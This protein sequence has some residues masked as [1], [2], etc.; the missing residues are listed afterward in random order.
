MI[1]LSNAFSLNMLPGGT[2]R[3][4]VKEVD[5][6]RVKEM[7]SS[8]FR[9]VVGHASTASVLSALLG[10]DVEVRREQ[11]KLQKN[12]TCIVF[13]LQVRLEEGK[14]LSEEELQTLPYKFY[15]VKIEEVET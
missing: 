5:V 6:E 4:E 3:L 1:Y 10:L 14:I 12:D 11:V 13:Q 15:V 2:V 7:L 8:G 9:S